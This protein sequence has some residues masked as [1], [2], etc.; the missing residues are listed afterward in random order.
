MDIV[1]MSEEK[2]SSGREAEKCL[3]RG[4]GAGGRSDAML[5]LL[6]FFL[7]LEDSTLP[8]QAPLLLP[9]RGGKPLRP[10]LSGAG[11]A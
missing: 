10:A 6:P 7:P 8:A 2:G 4:S 5:T 11:P 1:V 3:F 9:L